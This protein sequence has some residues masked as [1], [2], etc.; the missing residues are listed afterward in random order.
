MPTRRQFLAQSAALSLASW[1]AMPRLLTQAAAAAV[2][3]DKNDH[4]LV[5]VELN[6]G[7][8]GLNTIVPFN[9]DLYY[10]ARPKLGLPKDQLHAI[11]D[12]LGLHPNL[13]PLAKFYKDGKV[14]VIQ[15]IG[16]PE[17]DR[18]HFRSMEIWHVGTNAK[19]VP[20]TGWLGRALDQS[21]APQPGELGAMA[22]TGALPQALQA[23]LWN[24]P[25]LQQLDTL[26]AAGE[27]TPKQKLLLKLATNGHS[28]GAADYLRKQA[29]ETYRTAERIRA[30]AEAYKFTV[31]YPGEFGQQ[32]KRAAQL[33]TADLGMRVLFAS[34]GGYD[35]H[36]QQ[37]NQHVSLFTELAGALD[38]F[39]RDLEAQNAADRV[40]V[41]V[42]SEFGRRVAENASLGTDHGAASCT[43]LL[44]N[45]V[46]GGLVGKY[47]G[48]DKLDD[49]D[50]IH[51]VDFR[52]VYATILDGWLSCP[53]EKVLGQKFAGLDL[54]RA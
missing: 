23:D 2:V 24:V 47:P 22:L 38:A 15:G 34:Q 44:G 16:Y 43:F 21:G 8:D 52:S 29:A 20:A 53:S 7:N 32:L 45:K 35:T 46:R 49:G 25:V 18:S 41:L 10:K 54:L 27:G 14:A 11:N 5:V 6:G 37:A 9:D 50:L 36:S 19:R 40:I 4:V 26:V 51:T 30:A 3:A 17:P 12:D 31:D 33:I 39:Q 42:F 1:A 48:L 13:A 28:T